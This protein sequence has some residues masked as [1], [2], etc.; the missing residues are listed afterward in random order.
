MLT[1]LGTALSISCA[2][3]PG[4]LTQLVEAR[5][6]ASELRVQFTKA[7]ETGNR[8]VMAS[9][10]DTASAA[11]NE[12]RQ[13]TEAVAKDLTSLR[14]TLEALDYKEELRLLE[15]FASSFQEYRRIDDELLPLAVENTNV[16]AQALSFGAATVAANAFKDSLERAASY[17]TPAGRCCVESLMTGAHAALLEIRVLH[18]PHIAE[19][20]D[21]AMTQME[22]RMTA[23][24]EEARRI[25]KRLPP[26]L[27]EAAARPLADASTALEQ[28]VIINREIVTLS[29]RNSNVRSLALTLGRKRT[30]TATCEDHLRALDEAL[31]RHEFTATR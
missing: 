7:A 8:A 19:A 16:K 14:A 18:A 3:T 4:V 2:G 20:D 1:G 29:R 12:S 10:E 9:A 13:A 27:T 17:S 23:F 26:L 5:R 31:S 28:F 24:E 21:A 25:L 22:S 30:V 6:L 11:A 15:A